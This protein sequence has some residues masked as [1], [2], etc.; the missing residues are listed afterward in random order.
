MAVVTSTVKGQIV[1]PAEIR[2]KLNINKGT[3]VTVYQEGD[4]IVVEPLSD[5]PVSQGR[6]MLRTRGKV[7]K[8]LIEDRRKE[9]KK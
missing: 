1:I 6:G 8:A 5:D 9:A 2:K 7:L 3:R 4:R